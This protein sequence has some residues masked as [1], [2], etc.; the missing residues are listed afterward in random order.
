VN[1]VLF[2]TCKGERKWARQHLG[3]RCKSLPAGSHFEL[4][5]AAIGGLDFDSH[6]L[7][8]GLNI[9]VGHSFKQKSNCGDARVKFERQRG[10]VA[11]WGVGPAGQCR[12]GHERGPFDRG[13]HAAARA[14]SRVKDR[15]YIAFNVVKSSS[16]AHNTPK[17]PIDALS[18]SQS[19]DAETGEGRR[20]RRAGAGAARA[21]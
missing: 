5:L 15:L 16:T 20:E 18:L 12:K 11:A 4:N 8:R 3:A 7:V 13:E 19:V 14:S 21:L 17:R 6:R 2:L 10:G 1:F 9:G